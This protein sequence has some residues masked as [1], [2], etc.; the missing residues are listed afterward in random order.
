MTDQPM[1][2]VGHFGMFPLPEGRMVP[3]AQG[4]KVWGTFTTISDYPPGHWQRHLMNEE[5]KV[6]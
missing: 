1:Q 3:R 2:S 6:K 5:G 4:E